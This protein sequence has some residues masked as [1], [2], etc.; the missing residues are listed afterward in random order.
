MWPHLVVVH[1]WCRDN[2]QRFCDGEKRIK[3][4]HNIMTSFMDDPSLISNIKMEKINKT[5]TNLISWFQLTFRASRK[6][7]RPRRWTRQARRPRRSR[8]PIP[9]RGRHT[10]G[11]WS[12]ARW[13][14]PSENGKYFQSESI[15]VIIVSTE[16]WAINKSSSLKNIKTSIHWGPG[17][18]TST[19]TGTLYMIHNP[20]IKV[21]ISESTWVS[22][23]RIMGPQWIAIIKTDWA[24]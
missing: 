24:Y 18:R 14:C 9:S 16:A 8:R 11:R 4:V 5:K 23:E 21:Q 10:G 12:A 6:R 1:K 17:I 22:V 13:Q 15:Y 2:G 19:V 7:G 3:I 20:Y